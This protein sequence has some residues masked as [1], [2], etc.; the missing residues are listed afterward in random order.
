MLSRS[1]HG[2]FEPLVRIHE[3]LHAETHKIARADVRMPVEVFAL[4]THAH[5]MDAE[6]NRL[7]RFLRIE[8]LFFSVVGTVFLL[9]QM[10]E[11]LHNRIVRRCQ[12]C[13][14]RLIRNTEFLIQ[15]GEQYLD[16]IDLRIVKIFITSEKV[17]EK[18]DMLRKP[19]RLSEGFGRRRIL[20]RC[21]R[22]CFRFQR[23]DGVFA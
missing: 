12:C 8:L 7:Q 11:I 23:I 6:A 3:S 20:V 16:G 4:R 2:V 17:F 21:I 14:I 10:V 22:P 9:A 19:R 1:Y 18:G 15:F 13:V 5:G